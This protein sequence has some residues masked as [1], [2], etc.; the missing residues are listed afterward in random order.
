MPHR[1]NEPFLTEPSLYE[2]VSPVSKRIGIDYSVLIDSRIR[3]LLE[4]DFKGDGLPWLDAEEAL[5]MYVLVPLRFLLSRYSTI[6]KFAFSVHHKSAD[7][8]FS[9]IPVIATFLKNDQHGYFVE[10]VLDLNALRTDC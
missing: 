1:S 6:L 10:V 4:A 7:G 3:Q 5:V 9:G 8:N 2:D